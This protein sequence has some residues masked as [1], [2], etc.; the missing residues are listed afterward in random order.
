M[1]PPMPYRITQQCVAYLLPLL[2]IIWLLNVPQMF[3]IP[4]VTQQVVAAALALSVTQVLLGAPYKQ[5]YSALNLVLA[6]SGGLAWLWYA[7]NFNDWTMRLGD[8]TPDMWVPGLIAMVLLFEALRKSVGWVLAIFIWLMVAYGLWGDMIPGTLQAEVFPL[9]RLTLYLYADSNGVPGLVLTVITTIVLPYVVLGKMLEIT[10]GMQ[11]FNDLAFRLVGRRRGGPAQVSVLASSFFG[12]LSGSTVANIMS[13]GIV[14][15]PVMKKT[16]FQPEQCAAIEAVASNGGQ[17]MPPIMGATAFIIAEFLE[18]P[19]SDVATAALIPA[20]VYFLTLMLKIDAMAV[21]QALPGLSLDGIP[22]MKAILAKGWN[23]VIPL[24]FL[25]YLLFARG[26][27]PGLAALMTTGLMFGGYLVQTKMQPNW[28]RLRT[29]LEESGQ[30]LAPLLVIG[31]A[32]GVVIGLMNS[33]GFAFQLSLAL[34]HVAESYGLFVLLALAGLISIILGMGMPTAAVYIILVTVIAPAIVRHGVDP[35]G[36]HLFLFYFGL[37]SMV[38]PPI[39][40][41]SIVAAKLAKADMWRTG[42]YGMRLALPAYLLPF[43]WIYNP[44]VIT[45]GSAWAIALACISVVAAAL[46]LRQSM[47]R[48]PLSAL[49]NWLFATALIATSVVVGSSTVW[50]GPEQLSV[51]LPCGLA[52]ALSYWV[53]RTTQARQASL[54]V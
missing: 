29:A 3:R 13:T 25:G 34:T 41:G 49:P 27:N 51:L 19:Y 32:A 42:F 33:T 20:L 12:M 39:A 15:I 38:T 14:T 50:L 47:L 43:L 7:W 8:R 52:F 16:G 17:I 5:R 54:T 37:L 35:L 28:Q 6:L 22:E 40:I 11:F 48:S 36:T 31:G 2:G 44:A 4:L 21:R 45:H 18:I 9:T 53:E 23:V 1:R 46:L 24:C 10:G 26:Y 30:E